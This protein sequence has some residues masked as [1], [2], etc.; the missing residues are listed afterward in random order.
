MLT[1]KVHLPKY[2]CFYITYMYTCHVLMVNRKM[3]I[4]MEYKK[5]EKNN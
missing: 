1:I 4:V 2:T 5:R 3:D